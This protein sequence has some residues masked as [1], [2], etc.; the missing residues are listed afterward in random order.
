M[1]TLHELHLEHNEQ[2]YGEFDDFVYA[3][4]VKY[5]ND[6]RK[7]YESLYTDYYQMGLAINKIDE[8]LNK[9]KRIRV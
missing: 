7:E 9:L 5:C 6:R 4:F 3:Y 2:P 1:K 8:E